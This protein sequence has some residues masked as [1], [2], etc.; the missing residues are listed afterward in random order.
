MKHNISETKLETNNLQLNAE[1]IVYIRKS[2]QFITISLSA[3]DRLVYL[4]QYRLSFFFFFSLYSLIVTLSLLFEP[5]N[6]YV[7]FFV[8]LL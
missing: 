5:S 6:I 4:L 2:N 8:P 7:M 1:I 3:L